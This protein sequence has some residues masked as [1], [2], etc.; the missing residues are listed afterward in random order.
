M[1]ADPFKDLQ[2][3][4]RKS[5]RGHFW[6]SFDNLS[7]Q[8]KE[9][10]S[11]YHCQAFP[12]PKIHKDTLINEVEILV[13]LGVLERQPASEWA[14]PLFIIPKKNS[15]RMCDCCLEGMSRVNAKGMD[16]NGLVTRSLD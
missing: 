11:L 4:S 1:E 5:P 2:G 7:F 14:S 10:V 12:V 15:V 8:L 6:E 3:M 9:S 13:K 16:T